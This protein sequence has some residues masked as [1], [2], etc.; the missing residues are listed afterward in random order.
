MKITN[1][2]LG[3]MALI[4]LWRLVCIMIC[5]VLAFIFIGIALAMSVL[6]GN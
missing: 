1:L 6:T 4:G 3:A 2:V 5:V